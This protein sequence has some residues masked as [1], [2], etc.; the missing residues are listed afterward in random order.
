MIGMRRIDQQE[1]RV[2]LAR[3]HRLSPGH[4]AS[5]VEAAT[6]SVIALHATDPATVYLSAWAR[7]DGF[8]VADLDRALYVE[9]SLVK[10]LA[11]RR[12]LFVLTREGV[13]PA[14]AG[15]SARVAGRERRRLIKEVERSGL[16]D[17]GERWLEAAT[18]AVRSALDGG[19]ELTSA[20]L[21][22]EIPLLEGS[23]R[24]GEGKPWGGEV[25]V[26]PR[27]LTVMSAAGLIL[28][29]SNDGA[30]RSSRP[31]WVAT[32]SWLG[33]EISVP[34]EPDGVLWLVREWLR[35]FGPGTEADLRWWLGSTLTAVRGALTDLRAVEV[36]IGGEIGYL[37]PDDLEPPEP[38]EPWAAL[39]PSLDPAAM[40]WLQRDW[41]LG[42]HG[43]QLYDRN[44]NAGHSA[45]L[46]GRIVG[47]W[48]Q[49]EDGEV[50]LQLLEDIGSDR[51][52]QIEAEA[53]RLTRWLDGEVVAPRYPSPLSKAGA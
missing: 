47:G 8:A 48:R 25:P 14:L 4:R 43:D 3:R 17:N 10:H 16:R 6:E 39:L 35:A 37:L 7:V 31:R 18:D 42:P 24:Y 41:Y 32:G 44:G 45:W 20:E 23:I 38:V 26:G 22:E 27:V 29:G 2:R 52:S 50:Q 28:R 30:W 12:T 9:R 15:A 51:L 13:G 40:G 53:E 33:E 1:R 49:A 36:E 11:M 46:D 21:R 34:A 19:R 5:S